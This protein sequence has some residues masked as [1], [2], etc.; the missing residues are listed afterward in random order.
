MNRRGFTLLELMV[1][2]L[3]LSMLVTVLTMVFNS[4]SVAWRTGT[5]GVAELKDVRLEL[6]VLHDVQDDLL[7]GLGDQNVKGGSGDSRNLNYRTVSLW[8]PKAD[9]ALRIGKRA[10]NNDSSIWWGKASPISIGDAMTGAKK[11]L[12]G[13]GSGNGA[14]LFTVG[15]R[16]AGPDGKWETEDDISTWPSEI[17]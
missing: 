6:G 3:L 2:S 4:A 11:D 5:A 14:G 13:A 8:D 12:S 17:D 1:A 10:F 15:V 16:S 9:N 7:P